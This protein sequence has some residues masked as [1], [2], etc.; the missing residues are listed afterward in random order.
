MGARD[1]EA[2]G[3]TK[4][5]ANRHE[6]F[7]GRGEKFLGAHSFSVGKHQSTSPRRGLATKWL[8]PESGTLRFTHTADR[9]NVAC[10]QC[11]VRSGSVAFSVAFGCGWCS[12]RT[13]RTRGTYHALLS[14][15]APARRRRDTHTYKRGVCMFR[16]NAC[17]KR[18]SH[19]TELRIS[20]P[21]CSS[22]R[23]CDLNSA[24]RFF[25]FPPTSPPGS[26]SAPRQH[27]QV[28]NR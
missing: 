14:I 22:R 16:T 11:I 6:A 23:W 12:S 21:A 15:C 7:F 19:D 27:R 26:P 1:S 4:E 28:Q 5:V 3:R 17:R 13:P 2:T 10:A 9:S 24:Q 25:V 18:G 8:G 20:D